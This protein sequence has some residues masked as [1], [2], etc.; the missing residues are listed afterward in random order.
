MNCRCH[1]EPMR[2]VKDRRYRAGGWWRCVVTERAYQHS[3]HYREMRRRWS[4]NKIAE[5]L[6]GKC[7]R[8]VLVTA[9]RCFDCASKHDEEVKL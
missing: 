4:R 8:D 9:S 6:C 3:D 5:G 7:G 1:G 2:W